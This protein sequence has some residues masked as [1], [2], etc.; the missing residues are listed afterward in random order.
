MRSG[1][2]AEEADSELV[3][4]ICDHL[5]KVKQALLSR[6]NMDSVEE[7]SYARSK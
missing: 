4:L 2:M 5:N 6:S 3:A 1:K 7:K